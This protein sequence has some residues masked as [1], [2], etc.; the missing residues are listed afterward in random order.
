[1]KNLRA[2]GRLCVALL[3]M[4]GASTASAE[5]PATEKHKIEALI[6]H[7]AELKGAKFVRNATPY[8]APT[9]AK[10]LRGKWQAN[11]AEIQSAGDFIDKAATKSGTTGK[12]Y[13]IRFKDG[14][15]RNSGEYLREQLKKMSEQSA[16]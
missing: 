10:F 14:A 9:A 5:L 16:K 13:L 15:E 12:P 2:P 4:L 1:M 8:D 11:E 3:F 7:V 6:K